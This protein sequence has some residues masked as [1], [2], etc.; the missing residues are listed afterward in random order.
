M[1]H[2]V[3]H[4]SMGGN[5]VACRDWSHFWLNEGFATFMAAA[6]TEHRLGRDAYLREMDARRA[7][8]EKVRDAG[9]DRS[10]VFPNWDRATADDRTLV[11]QKGAV[12]LHELRETL[13][14]RSFWAGMRRY[15]RTNFGKSVTAAD[16]QKA[17]E[18]SSGKSLSDFF[19]KWVY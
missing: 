5:Q 15:T 17:M 16:F 2:G 8:Y 3:F 12:V 6:Y 9:N 19:T 10:L 4:E 14:D 13:G 7:R 1:S 11:Y 18:Q